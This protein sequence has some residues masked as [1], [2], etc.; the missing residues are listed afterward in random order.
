[1]RIQH[2]LREELN[3]AI[4]DFTAVGGAGIVLDAK[5]GEVLAMVSL[6]DFDPNDP[7]AADPDSRFNRATLGV[8]EMGSTFKIFNTA[9]A[10]NAGISTM[11]S[12]YDARKPIRIGR[13]TIND[14]H[15]EHRF[16]TVPE[17]FTYSS[18][19]GAAKMAVDIGPELQEKFMK[20]IGMLDPESIELPELGDPLYPKN[21]RLVNCMTI[22]YGHGIAVTALHL[23]S[24]VAAIV[25]N[26]MMRP[27]TLLRRDSRTAPPGERVISERTSAEMRELMRMVVQTGTGKS[28]KVPGYDVGGKTG[29]AEKLSGR[30]YMRNAR[31]AAFVAAF[32]MSAPRYVILAM[33]DEPH[34]NKHS[35]GY[36]TGVWVAAPA[37]GRIVERM[38]PLLGIEPQPEGPPQTDPNAL[39]VAA[40]VP[41]GPSVAE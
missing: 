5:T 35:F 29:T 20:R 18:N 12:S 38:A 6:P 21:W 24:G 10:L 1:V 8:Y 2:I 28:A 11:T 4:E 41:D 39:L 25:E 33:V 40:S 3:K 16:L 32:P 22:A 30:H 31:M 14:F 34:P 7:G 15:P 13:Y 19:I 27:T 9:L 23:V 26:G 17:I 36:A 37:V